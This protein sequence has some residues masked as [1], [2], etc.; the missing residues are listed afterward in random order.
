MKVLIVEDV[1]NGHNGTF[2]L[3]R[4]IAYGFK[5]NNY[6]KIIYFGKTNDYKNVL[7][8]LNGFDYTI[9]SNKYLGFIEKK[10]ESILIKKHKNFNVYD[11]PSFISELYLFRYLKKIKF[12][13]DLIIFSSYFASLS[14]IFNKQ[15]NITY[16]HEAPIFDDF[17]IFIRYI[18]YLYLKIL[19]FKTKY[20]SIS[21]NTSIKTRRKFKFNII[22]ESPIAFIDNDEN[23]IKERFIL[24]DTRWTGDRDPFFVLKMCEYLNIKI[25]MHG[26]FTEK[27]VENEFMAGI[28]KHKYNIELI[29]NDSDENLINLYKKALI[30]LRFSG[31]H[32]SGNS[33]SIFY[34]ISY[35]CIPIIDKNLGLSKL[36][37]DN[38]SEELVVERNPESFVAIINKILTNNEFYKKLLNN[39]IK[40]KKMYSWNNYAD[41]LINDIN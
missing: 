5:K 41:K 34:G 35:N 10:I 14:M 7:S 11:I 31:L 16:L 8:L 20:V 4:N 27:N 2:K 40:T 21:E 22:T 39:T 9:L 26:I 30:V 38:I 1:L 33:L 28:N 6:V 13:P 24:I 25:I 23:Y 19:S 29:S 17:N 32:E 15:K 18:I 3:M 12:Y 37:A 36:I